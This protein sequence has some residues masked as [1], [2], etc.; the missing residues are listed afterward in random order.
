MILVTGSQGQMGSELVMAL[1]KRHGA[2]HVLESGRQPLSKGKNP[3]ECLRL[4]AVS[5]AN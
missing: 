5:N 4:S 2:D 3:Y 1:Q